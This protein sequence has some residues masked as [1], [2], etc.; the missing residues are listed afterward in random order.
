MIIRIN[1]RCFLA[2][3]LVGVFGLQGC[4]EQQAA[5]PPKGRPPTPVRVAEVV[6]RTVQQTVELVGTVEPWR[7][8]VVAG[9]I[10]AVVERFPVEEGMAVKRGDMLAQ[11]R[12]DTLSI[13]LNAAEA[14]HRESETRHQQAKKD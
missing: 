7:R 3:L 11:L 1:A 5:Q 13:Q 14:T 10:A 6:N 2:A 4:S 9:E 12:T 8:S